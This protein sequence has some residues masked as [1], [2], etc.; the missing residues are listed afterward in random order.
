MN[1]DDSRG[2][3]TRGVVVSTLDVVVMAVA[4]VDMPMVEALMFCGD[5]TIGELAM[6]V[7]VTEQV[8]A[9]KV[10]A[11]LVLEGAA[12]SFMASPVAR[13]ERVLVSMILIGEVLMLIFKEL[14]ISAITSIG[15]VMVGINRGGIRGEVVVM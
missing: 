3:S 4:T 14:V 1:G 8:G 7:L 10:M 5:A 15:L 11:M 9:I 12:I 6:A 2:I 13:Q